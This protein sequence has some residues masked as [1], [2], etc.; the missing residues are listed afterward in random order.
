MT[1]SK[2]VVLIAITLSLVSVVMVIPDVIKLISNEGI[3]K[4]MEVMFNCEE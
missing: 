2:I 1:V 3:Q 4:A